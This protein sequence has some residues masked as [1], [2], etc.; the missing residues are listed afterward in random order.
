MGL[1]KKTSSN[2]LVLAGRVEKSFCHQ[3]DHRAHCNHKLSFL[4]LVS[5]EERIFLMVHSPSRE[6]LARSALDSPG[7]FVEPF[8]IMLSSVQRIV[9]TNQSQIVSISRVSVFFV[10]GSRLFPF[11]PYPRH[12]ERLSLLSLATC[13]Q[14]IS[15]QCFLVED[16][17][18]CAPEGMNQRIPRLP[19]WRGILA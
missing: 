17:S 8:M 14:M 6:I 18:S 16:F 5:E 10:Q 11:E 12:H 3:N 19:S 7:S 1:Q 2:M 13:F 4:F 9:S 15:A